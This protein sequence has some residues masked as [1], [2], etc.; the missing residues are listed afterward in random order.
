MILEFIKQELAFHAEVPQFVREDVPALPTG[1]VHCGKRLV[2][3]NQ[4]LGGAGHR[5]ARYIALGEKDGA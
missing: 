2:M 4:P 3:I 5:L 1:K